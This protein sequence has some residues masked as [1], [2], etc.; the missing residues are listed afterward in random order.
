MRKQD[1]MIKTEIIY[2]F[3]AI[4]DE[5]LKYAVIA[6]RY[7]EKWVF[8]RHRDRTT[9]ELPGGHRERGETIC[10]TA[11]RELW[12][13][14]GASDADIKQICAYKVERDDCFSYGMLYFAEISRLEAIPTFSEISEIA[15]FDSIP[16]NMT[17]EDIHPLLFRATQGWLNLQS[18]AGEVWDIYDENRRPTGRTVRRGDVIAK[19]DYHL[20]VHVWMQNSRGEF[21]LTKR[22]PN[23]GYPN[24]W[25][26]TGGAA[27]AGDDSLAAALREVKEETGLSLD[28]TFGKRLYTFRGESDHLDVWLF[29]QDFDLSDV[30]LLEGE[31][32]DK[33]YAD[34][35]KIRE[36][37]KERIFV[38]YSYLDDLLDIS[39]N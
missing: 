23:K 30:V 34:A 36:L 38:P 12:E 17:Y 2:D 25:E 27:I 9:L 33:M 21:L 26:S 15:F 6:A 14:T 18:G 22:A 16:E 1:T 32:C 5:Q 20:S 24:M 29:K 28:S 11:R 10:Q 19:G 13:E 4:E 8:C 7:D 3:S 31:T 35:E 39:N 37:V